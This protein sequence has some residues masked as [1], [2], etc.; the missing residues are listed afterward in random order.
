MHRT[1]L[2][3]QVRAHRTS[4]TLQEQRERAVVVEG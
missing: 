1:V 3:R 2:G 4:S